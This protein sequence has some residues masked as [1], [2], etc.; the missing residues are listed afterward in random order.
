MEWKRLM[1][2]SIVVNTIQLI[3]LWLTANLSRTFVN[4]H[5]IDLFNA[6]NNLKFTPTMEEKLFDIMYG[7]YRPDV[8]TVK[9]Y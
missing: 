8:D 2:A 1:N 5:V 3:A 7:P 9:L 4:W 6:V